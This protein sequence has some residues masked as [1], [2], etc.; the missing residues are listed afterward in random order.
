MIGPRERGDETIHSG[1]LNQALLSRYFFSTRIILEFIDAM[2]VVGNSPDERHA[3]GRRSTAFILIFVFVYD[4]NVAIKFH[5]NA[6]RS[7]AC[8]FVVML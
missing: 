6:I 5:P 4:V 2:R 1:R 8:F 3:P 7:F